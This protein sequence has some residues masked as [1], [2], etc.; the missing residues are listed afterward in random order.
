MASE[1]TSLTDAAIALTI[2][3][4]EGQAILRIF[5]NSTQSQIGCYSALVTN[6]STL[7]HPQAV[8]A[9]LGFFAVV[10]V[11]ASL[12]TALYGEDVPTTRTHYAHS[13]S[14]GVVFAVLHHIYFSGALSMDWP[15]VLP[16][17]WSNF[18]WAA[19]M[20]YSPGMQRSINNFL[21]TNQGNASAVGAAAPGRSTGNGQ[22]FL[23]L[24][25]IYQLA[26]SSPSPPPPP[27]TRRDLGAAVAPSLGRRSVATTLVRRANA[28]ATDDF[29]WY[30]QPIKSGLP[31]PG[32]FYG[33]RGTLAQQDI[34]DSNAFLTGLLWLLVLLLVVAA[35]IVA[36]KWT[37]ELGCR[38]KLVKKD[39]LASFRSNWVRFT[40][41][42]VLRVVSPVPLFPH[43]AR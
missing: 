15:S 26:P 3:D 41:Q 7:S 2:P 30:G 16:A 9:V 20:I 43:E 1:G 14:V 8:G 42:A 37:L 17:F 21:R 38:I 29:A 28:N 6:G 19:G 31:L 5:A 25:S 23:L 36:L 33:F 39:R 11:V 13:L 4:F 18:A 27:P 10:A 35:A 12:A 32:D 34:P 22:S 24:E 40:W